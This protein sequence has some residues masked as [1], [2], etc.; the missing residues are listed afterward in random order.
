MMDLDS[1]INVKYS[2]SGHCVQ[3]LYKYCFKGPTQREQI[4]MN[5]EKMQ[6][7]EDKIK[8]FIY[9]Q[10]LCSMSAMWQF[11]GYQD[12]PASTPAVSSFKVP[13]QQQLDFIA[14]TGKV[15]DLQ[16]YYKRPPQLESLM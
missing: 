7:F 15:S 6:D 11:Y 13:T 3:Y 8:L 14:N 10:V 12:Y 16:V 5:S 4:K 9:R 1:H 2:G